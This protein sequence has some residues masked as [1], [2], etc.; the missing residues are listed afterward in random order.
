MATL[1]SRADSASRPET[2]LQEQGAFRNHAP[3]RRAG[4]G[5]TLSIFWRMLFHKPRNTRPVGDIPVQPLTLEQLLAAPNRSVYRLGHSTVLLKLH[6]K[7]WITDPVFAERASPVQWAGPKR[8]HQPPISLDEL[9]PIE[10]VILSHDHY[11]HLDHQTV[12]KLA[13]KTCNFLT[14]LGVGD[15]LVKWGVPADKVRQLDWWEGTEVDGI[16]FIATP[17]Q[18]FSGRGLFDGNNTLWASWV[19]IDGDSRIFFSGD[20]GYFDGFKR[21]G[22]RYGPFDLTLMETGAYNVEWPG[23]H[24]Q[25]EQTLQAHIDLKGHWLLPIHNGTFDLSMHAWYEPFDRILSLAWERSIAI[26]TPQMGEAFNLSHPQRGHAWWMEVDPMVEQ[27][28]ACDL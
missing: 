26:A 18:H 9:P 12:L 3:V 10:A 25:P 15:T 2:S 24:M 6:D 28:M 17:S 4:L 27:A 21:I 11:D 1:S 13:D 23:V 16:R 22:E 19:M 7:F 8:F 5:K 20:S 14:P